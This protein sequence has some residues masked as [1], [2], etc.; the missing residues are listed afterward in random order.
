[1]PFSLQK[2]AVPAVS[3]L[4]CF[5]AYT[6][7]LLFYFIEPGPLSRK[8]LLWFNG[9]VFCLW[10]SYAQAVRIDPGPKGWARKYGDEQAREDNEDEILKKGLRWCRKC[11]TIKPP[12]AHHCR[13]C[14]RC[15]PKMD[16]HCPWT[17]NCVSHTTFPHFLRFVL[18]CVLSTSLLSYFLFVRIH[19]LWTNRDMPSYLGPSV[20]A[21]AHLF[22]V[23]VANG[24]VLF[25]LAILLVRALYSL[26]INTTMIES[27]EIE[28]H[29]A[30]LARARK[31]GGYTYGSG[32]QKVYI[33]HQEFPYDIGVWKN[34]VQGMGTRNIFMWFL[35]FGKTPQISKAGTW[36]V[37]GFEAESTTWPPLDPDKMPRATIQ[38]LAEKQ[39]LLDEGIEAFKARQRK[40]YERFARLESD[41]DGDYESESEYEYEEGI[42]GQPG[43]TN[44]EGE[45][46]KDF[47]VDEDADF[48]LPVSA[49]VDDDDDIPLGELLRRRK[50]RQ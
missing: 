12:R 47:G 6:P 13:T 40:D 17:Q 39:K 36:E 20:W 14:G 37:N 9:L 50:A 15:I 32:G 5:I 41:D 48:M 19:I 23:S 44:S 4:I 27:W 45:R 31:S 16:H 49:A 25:A 24:L 7:I 10:W 2:F 38:H 33:R 18:Y 30:L 29:E 11:E 8:Q 22:A 28:R 43:W 46:L 34:L 21:I 26:A 35:P 1:M 42:D 3:G